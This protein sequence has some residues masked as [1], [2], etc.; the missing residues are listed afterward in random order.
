MILPRRVSCKASIVPGREGR[1]DIGAWL[2]CS[3]EWF[4]WYELECEKV[5]KLVVTNSA[6][7]VIWSLPVVWVSHGRIVSC[8][9]G[10]ESGPFVETAVSSE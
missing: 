4:P 3:V 6:E 9:V 10:L 7:Q 5:S 2:S 1:Y 8:R